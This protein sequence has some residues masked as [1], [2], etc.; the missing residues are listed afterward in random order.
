MNNITYLRRENNRLESLSELL[1][2]VTFGGVS[3]W[4]KGILLP[5]QAKISY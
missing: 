1:L 2:E 4:F 3:K 5:L